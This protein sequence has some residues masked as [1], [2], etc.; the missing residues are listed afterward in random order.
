MF[1][2]SNDDNISLKSDF[3]DCI[4]LS[5]PFTTST[6]AVEEDAAWCNGSWTTGSFND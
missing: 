1:I 6:K 3:T 2:S 4:R 5:I